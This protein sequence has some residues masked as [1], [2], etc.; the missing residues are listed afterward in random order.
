MATHRGFFHER[1]RFLPCVERV[2]PDLLALSLSLSLS[3]SDSV[4]LA[5]LLYFFRLC[6]S[7]LYVLAVTAG[8]SAPKPPTLVR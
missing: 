7:L 8:V 5:V 3:L 1:D 4:A 2:G 6:T